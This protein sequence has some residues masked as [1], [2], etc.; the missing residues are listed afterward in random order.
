MYEKIVEWLYLND[1]KFG[2]A[3]QWREEFLKYLKSVLEPKAKNDINWGHALLVKEAGDKF[4][5][6]NPWGRHK[7]SK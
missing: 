3:R 5:I 4:A 7:E 2:S 1:G 6:F